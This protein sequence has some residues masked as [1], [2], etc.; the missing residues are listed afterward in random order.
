MHKNQIVGTVG[1]L[2]WLF[3]TLGVLV[4]IETGKPFIQT[5]LTILFAIAV[6]V[7]WVMSAVF[8]AMMACGEF[9]RGIWRKLCGKD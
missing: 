6:I 9:N 8:F 2:V 4:Y 7:V 3:G 1:G 5:Y